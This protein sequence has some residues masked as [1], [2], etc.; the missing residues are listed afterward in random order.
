[1]YVYSVSHERKYAIGIT[2][3][4]LYIIYVCAVA[5]IFND[6]FVILEKSQCGFEYVYNTL[7]Y[8]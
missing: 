6:R 1:M 3:G 5:G 2:S 4:Q 8:L 7:L